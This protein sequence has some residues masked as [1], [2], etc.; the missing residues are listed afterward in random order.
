MGKKQMT[1]RDFLAIAA[2]VGLAGPILWRQA[3]AAVKPTI[4][5]GYQATLWG[6][7]AIVAEEEKLFE[8]VGAAVEVRRFSS[9]VHV[10]DAMV[11]RAVDVGSLGGTPFI[12]GVAKGEM[13]AVG[14][15]AYA[16]RTLMVVAAKA[17]GI[18]SVADLKGKKVASQRGSIT[19]HVFQTQ[20]VPKHGLKKEDFQV[21][22]VSFQDHVA[23]LASK[24]VD[25]F[26]GVEPYP[27]IAEHQGIGVVLLDYGAFDLTPV[28]LA[29]N[30]PALR[31]RP[32]AV[33]EFLRAWLGS[34]RIFREEPNRAVAVLWK[35]FK[36]QGYDVP[37]EV[38]RKAV[39][40]LDVN[41]DFVPEL[42]PYLIEQSQLL[43]Q[44]GQISKVPD[45]D[46][47]L[48]RE[49]LQQAMRR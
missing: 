6:A 18:R 25:A 13:A 42:K 24:S 14:A 8:K 28:L 16:G 46:S 7:T 43:V 33:V 15:V 36:A 27:S 40:R 34:V 26:A 29:I 1:R 37:E 45:W 3:R 11:A 21:V 48:V 49:P 35:A 9:G 2:G 10:R 5:F 41:P 38:I 20:I 31:D 23:A 22:N 17:S 4:V 30:R 44:R 47:A 12:V 19:D 39:S 32:D